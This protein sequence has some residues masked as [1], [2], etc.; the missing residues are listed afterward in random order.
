MDLKALLEDLA[1]L[2][3]G[4]WSDRL[5]QARLRDESGWT[6]AER[7]RHTAL[8]RLAL[9]NAPRHAAL[10]APRLRQRPRPLL[11]AAL[12]LGLTLLEDG[13]APH[14]VLNELL[15]A[16]QERSPQERS[17]VNGV[18]RGWLREQAL[19]AARP[20]PGDFP[21][22]FLELLRSLDGE[23]A[24]Q[25]AALAGLRHQLFR[26][27]GTWLRVNLARWS[28]AGALAELREA[29]LEPVA[30]PE[31]PR[32]LRLRSLPAGGLD[33]LAPLQ[34]G[35]L[36]VQDLSVWGALA[37]LD[38]PPGSRVLDLCAAPGG[39]ALALLEA[40]PALDLTLVEAHAGRARALARRLDGRGRLVVA[41][42]REF[43]GEA[44]PRILLDAPCSGSGSVG[45]RPEILAKGAGATTELLTLQREL[46]EQAVALLAPGGRLVYSTCS[47]D[48]RENAGQLEALLARHPELVVR[49]ELVPATFRDAAGGWSWI[50]WQRPGR[51][52]AGRPGAGGAWAAAVEKIGTETRA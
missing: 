20:T 24:L 48:P 27:R 37:L 18:L 2:E 16:L 46:L 30:A 29:G 31:C 39:K 26:E 8:W 15:D 44:W 3:G 5:L 36:A 38:P 35:R 45:H 42:G 52:P 21:P 49:P 33:A 22:W 13:H 11:R 1:R 14:A 25:P 40:D 10:L 12:R 4:G 41:D 23:D 9:E 19:P 28:P 47:L 50:P 17:L 32:Y 34:D 51:Q 7:A 43:Q 6:G